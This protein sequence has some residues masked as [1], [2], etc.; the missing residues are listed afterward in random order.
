M[1]DSFCDQGGGRPKRAFDNRGG[2]EGEGA[3]RVALPAQARPPPQQHLQVRAEAID[4]PA[5]NPGEPIV[6]RHCP[7]QEGEGGHTMVLRKVS[8]IIPLGNLTKRGSSKAFETKSRISSEPGSLRDRE[9]WVAKTRMP[10]AFEECEVSAMHG[11]FNVQCPWDVFL[12]G[13][14]LFQTWDTCV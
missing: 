9:S 12:F 13:K 4:V 7:L 14:S 1:L 10:D 2:A 5:V 8:T 3:Q 6:R 11:L